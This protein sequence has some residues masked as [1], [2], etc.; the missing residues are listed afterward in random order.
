MWALDLFQCITKGQYGGRAF[1]PNDWLQA[2]YNAR[3]HQSVMFTKHHSGESQNN[4]KT[5][6][7]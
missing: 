6:A 4:N 7:W 3:D 1:A 5:T 2:A